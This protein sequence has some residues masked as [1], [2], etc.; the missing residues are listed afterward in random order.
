M[1]H[2]V[3]GRAHAAAVHYERSVTLF[4]Q[5]DDRRKLAN[6][7][8]LLALCGP[9]YQSSA[10][11]PFASPTV[12]GELRSLRS[13]GLA[14]EIGWRAGE[15]FLRFILADCFV[16]RGE[17]DRALPLAREALTQAQEIEHRQWTAGALRVL[18]A[19]ALD[20]LCLL[21]TSDAAD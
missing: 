10:T 16:G 14:R 15:S 20:L 18:G 7:L 5:L 8:G 9:S 2:H 21:Y 17:Y 4:T 1:A 13:L 6:A 3:G 19:M 11:T 12:A